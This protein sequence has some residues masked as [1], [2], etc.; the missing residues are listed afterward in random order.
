[1]RAL[2][3]ASLLVACGGHPHPSQPPPFPAE[4]LAAELD[5][6]MGQLAA[7]TERD[8]ENC[9]TLLGDLERILAAAKPT[10]DRVHAAEQDPEHARQLTTAM[11]AYDDRAP[12]RTTD[13]ATGLAVCFRTHRELQDRVQ[14]VVDSMPTL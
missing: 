13:I 14:R 3:I 1:M 10:F 11:H 9:V 5:G 8:Q 4:Q 12:S 6:V 7:A 2:I